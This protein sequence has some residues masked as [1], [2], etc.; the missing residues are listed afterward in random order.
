MHVVTNRFHGFISGEKLQW[1]GVVFFTNWHHTVAMSFK[2]K[3]IGKNSYLMFLLASKKVKM[4]LTQ[5]WIK[6]QIIKSTD[7]HKKIHPASIRASTSLHILPA[8]LLDLTNSLLEVSNFAFCWLVFLWPTQCTG[9]VTLKQSHGCVGG[10]H[11]MA[12]L[13]MAH[14]R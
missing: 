6:A 1:E 10:H 14:T 4:P 11:W 13:Y 5:G 2:G 12:K 7:D 8:S 9:W 3:Y